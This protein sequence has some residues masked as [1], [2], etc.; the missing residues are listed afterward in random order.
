MA[1]TIDALKFSNRIF[2][3]QNRALWEIARTRLEQ[4]KLL[5]NELGIKSQEMPF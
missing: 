2:D 3:D 1:K 5:E 4:I